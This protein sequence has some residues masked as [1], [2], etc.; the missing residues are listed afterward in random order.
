VVKNEGLGNFR[1]E[2]RSGASAV[3]HG[4]M[5]KLSHLPG[6]LVSSPA[7][8]QSRPSPGGVRHDSLAGRI[9]RRSPRA[10]RSQ[11]PSDSEQ[12][13]DLGRSL[14]PTGQH[15][16][17]CE[18]CDNTKHSTEL[19]CCDYCN[20]VWHPACLDLPGI[21]MSKYWMCHECSKEYL[22]ATVA[23]SSAVNF[24]DASNHPLQVSDALPS[25][26]I[27]DVALQYDSTSRCCCIKFFV[28]RPS[29]SADIPSAGIW[30]PRSAVSSDEIQ[31]YLQNHPYQSDFIAGTS[32]VKASTPRSEYERSLAHDRFALLPAAPGMVSVA[33][34]QSTRH[35]SSRFYPSAP[36]V[37]SLHLLG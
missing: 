22:P 3:V 31:D 14:W 37:G 5:L 28:V 24:V 1:I 25:G 11:P 29:T 12:F 27:L 26:S 17:L 18:I 16:D 33:A 4:D 19:L 13:D 32:A 8:P 35:V 20:L 9:L 34:P 2:G 21:P 23:L 30:V 15:N 6:N 7:V 10:R 36:F